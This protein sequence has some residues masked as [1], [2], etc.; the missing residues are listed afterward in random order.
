MKRILCMAFAIVGIG[1]LSC[2][3]DK[4]DTPVSET[5][6][7]LKVQEFSNSNYT[8][9]VYTSTGVFKMGYNDV[10]LRLRENTTGT[11]K[12]DVTFSWVP[13][14]NMTSMSHSCPSS[15]VAK[16]AGKET[17][18]KGYLIFQ[19]PENAT[20]H[21]QLS[22]SYHTGI[23]NDIVFGQIS[24]P[25][26][27]YKEVSVFTGSDSK[28]YIL[29]LIQPQNPVVAINNI[30]LGLFTMESMTAFPPVANYSFELDPRMPDMGNHSSPNNENP[31]YSFS[32]NF[33]QGKLSLTMTGKWK[34][35]LIVKNSFGETIKG[36]PVS[37]TSDSSLYLE[38]EAH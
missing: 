36:E 2:K 29:A 13:L 6:G 8:V 12:N 23:E 28:K 32:S 11:Y 21:W 4:M 7:L 5:Q 19:M 30:T 20:E 34:L 16:V 22:I 17:L 31:V 18:Y 1:M 14:M 15:A 3:K 25:A 27:I 24:V 35:N 26:S 37:G 33:Y 10:Y 9:E 38:V